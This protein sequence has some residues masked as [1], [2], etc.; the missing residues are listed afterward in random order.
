MQH[1]LTVRSRGIIMDKEGRDDSYH[2]M[3]DRGEIEL[4]DNA[5]HPYAADPVS[6]VRLR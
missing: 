3:S 5:G 1:E 4:I 6:V 2:L